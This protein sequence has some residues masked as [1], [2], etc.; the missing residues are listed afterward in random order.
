MR[1]RDVYLRIEK[2]PAYNPVAPDDAEHDMYRRDCMRNQGHEDTRIPPGEEARRRL[3]AVVYRE[4]L[5]PDYAVPATAP[6]VAADIHEP[7]WERRV[8]GA[9]IYAQPTE[10]VRVHV[11]NDDDEPHSFHVHGLEYGIDSDGSWP[12][13]V[14]DATGRSDAICPGDE[15]T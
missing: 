14:A 8:P 2:L 3:D 10:R 12:F 4:Y 11:R 9:V 5:D 1:C 15:W 13:G 6:M 7:R